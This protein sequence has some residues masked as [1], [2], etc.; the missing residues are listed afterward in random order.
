VEEDKGGSENP[1]QSQRGP[2][3]VSISLA[4]LQ[5]SLIPIERNIGAT[6]GLILDYVTVDSDTRTIVLSVV[7][8][9]KGTC[10]IK[11]Y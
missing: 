6:T 3:F 10:V 9:I 8:M 7:L 2:H 1:K 11:E 5:L 4:G